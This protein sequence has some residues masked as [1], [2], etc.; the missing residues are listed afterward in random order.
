MSSNAFQIISVPIELISIM[1][2]GDI[3]LGCVSLN[4]TLAL[5][6][7]LSDINKLVSVKCRRFNNETTDQN[8]IQFDYLIDT[9][10]KGNKIRYV[11]TL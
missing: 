6:F 9:Y 3:I 4:D 1:E 7:F 8:C 11:S 10:T 2:A 5:Y